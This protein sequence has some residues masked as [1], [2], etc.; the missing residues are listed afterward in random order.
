MN[1]GPFFSRSVNDL[2]W[3]QRVP[4][5]TDHY[6][7]GRIDQET[8]GLTG[9]FDFTFTP[10]MTLQF[11]A[12]PFVSAG[13]YSD[14]KEVSDP[15]AKHY[16]DRIR[17]LSPTLE[18]N[19]YRQDLDGNGSVE[20]FR[21]PDF[22]V[23]QFRSTLVLRWEYKPGSL[24][25]LVWSQGRNNRTGNGN[26]AFRDNLDELFERDGENVFMLKVSYWITP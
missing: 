15:K 23:Q 9:R 3:V 24:L 5:E 21:N 13:T 10:N 16:E 14:F 19:R 6:V 4:T 7:F 2:Q 20:S 11:Y 25:Y 1:V 26:L 22:N 12:Q 17:R 8:V 18:D